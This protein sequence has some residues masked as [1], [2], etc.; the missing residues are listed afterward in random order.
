MQPEFSDYYTD[1]D[2]PVE[3]RADFFEEDPTKVWVTLGFG[4][5]SLS[6]LEARRL[7]GLLGDM[8]EDWNDMVREEAKNERLHGNR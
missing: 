4:S 6:A 2:T 5:I 3:V 7:H 1:D 8:L